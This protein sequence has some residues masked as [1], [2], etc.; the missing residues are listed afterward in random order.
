[1]N[2]FSPRKAIFTT[3]EKR[4]LIINNEK[5][6]RKK[7]EFNKEN[8]PN[9]FKDY[10]YKYVKLSRKPGSQGRITIEDD[11]SNT[12]DKIYFH[13]ITLIHKDDKN[14]MDNNSNS[15]SFYALEKL[16]DEG[17]EYV[18]HGGKSRRRRRNNKRKSNKRRK[19]FRRRSKSYFM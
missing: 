12:E 13:N 6:I 2:F 11:R 15:Y 16:C 1:M 19:T 3:D 17:S 4:N 8:L 10:D 7:N 14:I 18:N 9:N 5:F